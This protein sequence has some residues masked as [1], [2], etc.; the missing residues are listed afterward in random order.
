[1]AVIGSF[2]TISDE[3]NSYFID[4]DDIEQE[5]TELIQIAH[6]WT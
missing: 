3:H 5:L 1:M 2:K 4:T 6:I